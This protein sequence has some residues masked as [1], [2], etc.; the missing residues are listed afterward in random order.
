MVNKKGYIPTGITCAASEIIDYTS[1]VS[2]NRDYE[3]SSYFHV[4]YADRAVPLVDTQHEKIFRDII[5][6][7]YNN[8]STS[9]VP[10]SAAIP[11]HGYTLAAVNG[12]SAYVEE[13]NCY[14]LVFARQLRGRISEY[15][16][17][18]GGF[19]SL[20]DLNSVLATILHEFK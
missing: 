12:D 3:N 16:Y 15:N 1:E 19:L 5:N 13:E 20:T 2:L 6:C 4:F 9:G 14:K 17:E 11:K 10:I 7:L 18:L 8:I